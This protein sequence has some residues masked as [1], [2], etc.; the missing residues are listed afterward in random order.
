MSSLE[1][2]RGS[3]GSLGSFRLSR[4]FFGSEAWNLPR[5][6]APYKDFPRTCFVVFMADTWEETDGIWQ[7]QVSHCL[8]PNLKRNRIELFRA[9]SGA[10][11]S[12]LLRA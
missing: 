10:G 2:L 6:S 1:H 11:V 12:Q 9:G 7:V 4:W 8:F 5:R 3:L